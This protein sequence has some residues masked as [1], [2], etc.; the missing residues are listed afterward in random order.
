MNRSPFPNCARSSRLFAL[1]AFAFATASAQAQSEARTRGSDKDGATMRVRGHVV[2]ALGDKIAKARVWWSEGD[3][4]RR[5]EVTTSA[6]G[7]FR[8]RVPVGDTPGLRIFVHATAE[9]RH[10]GAISVVRRRALIRIEVP[11]WDAAELR[12]ICVDTDGKAVAGAEVTASYDASRVL[13]AA[14][15]VS[16]HSA[17]DGR[18]TLPKVPLG[19]IH[20]R[21]YRAGFAMKQQSLHLRKDEE[22]RVVVPRLA[23]AQGLAKERKGPP[24]YTL[25]ALARGPEDARVPALRYAISS[26]WRGSLQFVPSRMRGGKGDADG[27]FTIPG[28]PGFEYV[29]VPKAPGYRFEPAQIFVRGRGSIEGGASRKKLENEPTRRGLASINDEL[30]FRAHKIETQQA[31]PLTLRVRLLDPARLGVP[32]QRVLCRS[33]DAPGQRVVATSDR[34]GRLSFASPTSAGRRLH[35]FLL[36]SRYAIE[37]PNE[38][39]SSFREFGSRA[40]LRADAGREHEISLVPGS[41][42]RGVVRRR[43]GRPAPNQ[44]VALERQNPPTHTPRWSGFRYGTTDLRGRFEFRG[45]YPLSVPMRVSSRGS[46]GHES[47][48]IFRIDIKNA[49]D[50]VEILVEAPGEMRG[51][52]VDKKGVGVPGALI[53]IQRY[54]RKTRRTIDGTI[55]EV[56][57]DR[58]GRFAHRGLQPG[59]YRAAAS[60]VEDGDPSTGLPKSELSDF[61]EVKPA[62]TTRIELVAR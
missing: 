11:L 19:R 24:R 43:D 28:V 6:R 14:N 58:A 45:L 2:D 46:A 5:G 16:A 36:G 9:G 41:R 8:L 1:V 37:N 59:H 50:D 62:A 25:R 54:D 18:F 53:Q 13:Q 26:F 51:R 56:L 33:L 40:L 29:V 38:E 60:L 12:G 52:F 49:V 31:A 15:F 48:E 44:R 20:L 32:H 57:T 17:D 55:L 7:A 39:I 10:V 22:L 47:S 4:T 30:R 35:L 61:L 34:E 3:G 27:R 23:V 21:A 42:V